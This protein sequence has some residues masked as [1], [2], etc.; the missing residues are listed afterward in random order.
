MVSWKKKYGPIVGLRLGEFRVVL[1]NDYDDIREA[2][3]KVE[4]NGRPEFKPAH[5]FA[6]GEEHGTLTSDGDPWDTIRRFTMKHLNQLGFGRKK[7]E[8]FLSC[9]ISQL[10]S[11]L[12]QQVGTSKQGALID[13]KDKFYIP[14]TNHLWHILM[15]NEIQK[16][17]RP[18]FQ[19]A[20][21]EL[22]K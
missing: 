12:Q 21:V 2:F 15:G 18:A 11:R 6:G 17:E 3:N 16:E 20:L 1:L 9:D 14:A 19:A 22:N 10:N 4:F 7:M 8:S 13:F 5:L